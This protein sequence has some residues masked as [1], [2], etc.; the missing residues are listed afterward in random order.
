MDSALKESDGIRFL[1]ISAFLVGFTAIGAIAVMLPSGNHLT[2]REGMTYSLLGKSDIDV[3][4]IAGM[5]DRKL[6]QFSDCDES[7]YY[8][9]PQTRKNLLSEQD[10]AMMVNFSGCRVERVTFWPKDE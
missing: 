6:R 2:S 9:F 7:W 8:D 4:S 1:V 5:P 10:T 3:A